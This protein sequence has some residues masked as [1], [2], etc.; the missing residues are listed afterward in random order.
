MEGKI[1]KKNNFS[2]VIEVLELKDIKSGW[3]KVDYYKSSD[4]NLTLNYITVAPFTK[5]KLLLYGGNIGR[6]EK[7]L[8]AIFDMIKNECIKVD[9]KI[10]EDIKLEEK[11]IQLVDF[12]IKKIK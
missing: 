4:L 2:E 9:N 11:K 3:I 8:F 1:E 10:M 5:D 6:F 12:A 7:K